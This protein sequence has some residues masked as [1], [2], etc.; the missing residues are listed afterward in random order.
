MSVAVDLICWGQLL[1]GVLLWASLLWFTSNPG[2]VNGNLIACLFASLILHA[3][4][5]PADELEEFE[6]RAFELAS[7]ATLSGVPQVWSILSTPSSV[8]VC[9]A[10][11][12][13]NGFS[14]Q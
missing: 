1:P 14:L 2:V 9:G 6:R 7:L 10:V 11:S 12:I 4:S 3:C 5:A 8:G 13:P